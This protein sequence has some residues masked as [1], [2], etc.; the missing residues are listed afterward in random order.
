LAGE[1]AVAG[2]G[3]KDGGRSGRPK[4][5]SSHGYSN[6]AA[7]TGHHLNMLIERMLAFSREKPSE[8]TVS[9]EFKRALAQLVV[10]H[11]AD[12]GYRPVS[13]DEVLEWS[14]R[15]RPSPNLTLRHKARRSD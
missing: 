4:T 7:A 9:P 3:K 13:V 5:G 1:V 10:Q 8:H 6:R 11:L 2:K 15:Y 14:R 12:C